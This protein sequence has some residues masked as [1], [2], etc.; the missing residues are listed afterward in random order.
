VH[1]DFKPHNVLRRADGRICVTDFGLARG[2]EDVNVAFDA[3]VRLKGGAAPSEKRR[4]R[5]QA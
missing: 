4:A 3:T 1:R 5:C 2:V